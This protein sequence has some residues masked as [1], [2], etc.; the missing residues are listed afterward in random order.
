MLYP[1]F[2]RL[3]VFVTAAETGSFAAAAR[4]LGISQPSI[5]SHIQS[6]E[7]DLAGPL[8]DREPGRQPTLN[9]AGRTFLLHARTL[10]ANASKL[11]EGVAD[12]QK[13][14]EQT[15]A[16]AC[17]RS[18][19]NT[20][21]RETLAQFAQR[22]RD[23]RTMVRIAF[24]EE[25]IASIRNGTADIGY[26]VSNDPIPDVS[27]KLIG[28]VR[29]V[30]FA[31]PEHPL[32]QRRHIPPAELGS[33]DFVGPPEESMFGQTVARMLQSIGIEPLR[34]VSRGTEFGLVR[35]LAVLGL[36]LC[37]SLYASVSPDL[38]AG[39]LIALD[40]DAPPLSVNVLELT[41]PK[42]G[43]N[44]PMREFSSLLHGA[45]SSWQ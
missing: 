40:L 11:E 28:R 21:M 9:E 5:S 41:N 4:R 1:T 45:A 10:L 42:R 33:Y 3:H 6:L 17:Q 37:C 35:D 32:A 7:R 25:V 24:Q 27:A 31:A 13:R 38:A 19:A 2:R 30:I 39:N 16:L 34:I 36:G 18:L 43:R 20:V 26:L 29:C 14:S 44:R 15:L 23:I 12:R 8:F 22:H